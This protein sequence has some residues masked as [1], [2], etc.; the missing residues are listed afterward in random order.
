VVL[1]DVDVLVLLDVDV[2]VLL[3]VD[4]LVLLDVDVLVLLD[5]DVLVLLEV[6]VLVLVELEVDVLVL[7]ELEVLVVEVVDELVDVVL[8]VLVEVVVVVGNPAV[9][10]R[11]FRTRPTIRPNI[12][13]PQ[14]NRTCDEGAQ[15]RTLTDALRPTRTEPATNTSTSWPGAPPRFVTLSVPRRRS[16]VTRTSVGPAK[17]IEA[18]RDSRRLQNVYEPGDSSSRPPI[19]CA[20]ST[21]TVP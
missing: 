1:L 18:L 4:V 16:R 21:R 11:I 17:S 3:D 13:T 7:V 14:A 15:T 20:P 9:T 10:S 2:L 6:D 8:L 5:V 12:E 19:P